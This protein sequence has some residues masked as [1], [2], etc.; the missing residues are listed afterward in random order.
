MF[1][2]IQKKVIPRLRLGWHW[3]STGEVPNAGTAGLCACKPVGVTMCLCYPV[4][5]VCLDW[6]LL[7]QRRRL[8]HVCLTLSHCWALSVC[9]QWNESHR[10]ALEIT[11]LTSRRNAAFPTSNTEIN[12]Y[13]SFVPRSLKSHF[14]QDLLIFCVFF[15]QEFSLGIR[16]QILNVHL[17]LEMITKANISAT[18]F[19]LTAIY[20]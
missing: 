19:I 10:A 13:I 14:I 4:R 5:L 20:C 6:T 7:K 12:T 8:L 17:N 3:E 18:F 9:P 2:H 15:P 11:P 1:C 16:N